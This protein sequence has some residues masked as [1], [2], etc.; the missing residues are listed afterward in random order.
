MSSIFEIAALQVLMSKPIQSISGLTARL[1]ELKARRVEEHERLEVLQ[2]EVVRKTVI[3]VLCD[4]LTR[5]SHRRRGV[6]QLR[7]IL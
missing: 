1:D 6:E 7:S 2:N 5:W 3:T 4:A